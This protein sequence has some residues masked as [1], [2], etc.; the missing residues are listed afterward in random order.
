[1]QEIFGDLWAYFQRPETTVLITTNGTIKK[2]GRCVMGKG[3]A[4]QARDKFPGIDLELGKKILEHGNF[5]HPL[6]NGLIYSFP[7]KH[8]WFERA[9]LALIVSSAT[10]LDRLARARAEHYIYV[11]PR[12]GCKNGQLLWEEVK[13]VIAFLPDNVWVITNGG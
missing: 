2:T 12:P 13:P 6:L 9:D 4:R 11:L 10:I 1:M 5:P 3:N 7:V 8:Q